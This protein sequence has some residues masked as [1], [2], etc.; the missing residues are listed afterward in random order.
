MVVCLHHEAYEGLYSCEGE[1]TRSTNNLTIK[2]KSH[3][4]HGEKAPSIRGSKRPA[5][6]YFQ[7]DDH[8]FE[9]KSF[10]L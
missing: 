1:K 8:E 2:M 6:T 7:A 9:G 10:L 3:F 4:K 5:E